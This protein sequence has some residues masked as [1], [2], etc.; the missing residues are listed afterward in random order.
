[1]LEALRAAAPTS[2]NARACTAHSRLSFAG[3]PSTSS[4]AP[5]AKALVGATPP[6]DVDLDRAAEAARVLALNREK[7]R[8][9]DVATRARSSVGGLE[10]EPPAAGRALPYRVGVACL[11]GYARALAAIAV[12]ATV[13]GCGSGAAAQ[14]RPATLSVLAGGRVLFRLAVPA[15]TAPGA[16]ARVVARRLPR[17]IVVRHGRA[18][19]DLALSRAAAATAAEK[20]LA[21]HRARLVV[22]TRA[23]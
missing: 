12:L 6:S 21:A 2:A 3:A 18:T 13:A 11:N 23:V 20:A 7:Q 16:E 5:P 17:R 15:S 1:M 14:A 4:E 8:Q 9:L 19:I 22:P 10:V